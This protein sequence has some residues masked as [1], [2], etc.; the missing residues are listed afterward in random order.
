MRMEGEGGVK[1]VSLSKYW[2]VY[3]PDTSATQHT[4]NTLSIDLYFQKVKF[5]SKN[6]VKP[7]PC[8]GDHF[9]VG[10]ASWDQVFTV[11]GDT[12]RPLV[13]TAMK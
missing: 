4:L 7:P 3:K 13:A 12:A 11:P 5:K 9:V 10:D 6:Q 1:S 2:K 8:F